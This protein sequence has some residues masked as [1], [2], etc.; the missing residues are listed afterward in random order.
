M[1]HYLVPVLLAESFI[2]RNGTLLQILAAVVIAVVS[3]VGGWLLRRHNQQTKT[4]DYRV[5]SDLPILS[6]RPDDDDLKVTYMGEEV[7]HPRIVRVRFASTGKQVIR[8]TDFLDEYVLRVRGSALLDVIVTDE[9]GSNLVEWVADGRDPLDG[10]ITLAIH[11]LNPGDTFTIQMIVDGQNDTQ[12]GLVSGRIEGESRPTS[13]EPTKMQL[14]DATAIGPG[15]TVAGIL[16]A[17][18]G[19]LLISSEETSGKVKAGLVVVGLIFAAAG[20]VAAY[21]RRQALFRHLEMLGRP[22]PPWEWT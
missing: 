22:K 5:V 16:F 21:F 6:N 18:L 3:A 8:D 9:T 7:S 13:I 12:I 20:L 4:F 17:L 15:G 14:D 2:E 19:F 10:R 11:T 1:T